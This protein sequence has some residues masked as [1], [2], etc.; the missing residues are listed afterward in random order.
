MRAFKNSNSFQNHHGPG[1]GSGSGGGG[2]HDPG[3]GGGVLI[4]AFRVI[5]IIKAIRV[6][7]INNPAR[8]VSSSS[9]DIK[10]IQCS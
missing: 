7:T 8:G 4:S 6:V 1:G 5:K 2:S 10:V 3:Y 9:L